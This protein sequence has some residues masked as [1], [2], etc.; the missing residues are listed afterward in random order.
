MYDSNNRKVYGRQ[1]ERYL[2][3]KFMAVGVKTNCFR[4]KGVHYAWL[5]AVNVMIKSEGHN[6][7]LITVPKPAYYN[8]LP[9]YR[10]TTVLIKMHT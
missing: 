1:N 6:V 9:H 10:P 5:E 3:N 8:T 7:Y 4:L 2:S